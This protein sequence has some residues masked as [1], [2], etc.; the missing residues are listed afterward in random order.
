MTNEKTLR[1]AM[2]FAFNEGR[3]Y[4]HVIEGHPDRQ[5]NILKRFTD[6]VA[7]WAKQIDDSEGNQP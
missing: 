6:S 2:M 5:A 7:Y 3:D 1:D 4:G